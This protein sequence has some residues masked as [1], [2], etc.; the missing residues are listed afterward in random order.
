MPKKRPPA[1]RGTLSVLGRVL[2]CAMF[3]AAATPALSQADQLADL[4]ASKGPFG[5]TASRAVCIGLLALGCVSVVLGYRARIGA[6]LLLLFLVLSIS[7]FHGFSLWALLSSEAR[8]ER[9]AQ[10][11]ANLSGIGAM[12]FIVANGPGEMSLDHWR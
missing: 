3:V 10:L 2:L 12:L 5:P 8:G 11:A 9:I 7:Y 4:L 1:I 6:A